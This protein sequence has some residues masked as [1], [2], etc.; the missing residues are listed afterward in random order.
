MKI[1]IIGECMVELFDQGNGQ[2]KRGFGGDTLNTAVYLARCAQSALEVHYVTALGDDPLSADMLAQW[3]AEGLHTDSVQQIP[4]AVPGLYMIQTDEHGERSFLYWR[5]Q[6][7][8]KK[9]FQAANT[10]RLIEQLLGF[11]ALYYSGI[12]LAVLEAAGRDKLLEVLGQFRA[13]GG[14]V[15]FDVNYRPRLWQGEDAQA[16]I[17][18]AY[19]CCD[20]ALPSVDDE[21]ALW[22][23]GNADDVLQRLQD[24]G[25]REIV[26]KRGGEDCLI[27]NNGEVNTYPVTPVDRVVDTTAAGDSFNGGYLASRLQQQSIATAVKAGQSIAGQVISQQGAIVDVTL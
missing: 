9:L 24:F 18:A 7:P 23:K 5:D 8:V 19:R 6:A 12:T 27:S 25:C 22:G 4:G 15:I 21:Y 14:Q 2:C 16:W 11:D 13:K 3:Q 20:L 10:D 17:T 26:L 1:G